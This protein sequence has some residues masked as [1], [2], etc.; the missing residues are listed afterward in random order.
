MSGMSWE[1]GASLCPIGAHLLAAAVTSQGEMVGLG[2][3]GREAPEL[4]RSST[5][6]DSP[7]DYVEGVG[8]ASNDHTAA[9]GGSLGSATCS[10]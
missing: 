6:G 4:C 2:S 1:T 10:S 9:P 8:E 7:A 5:P 3:S